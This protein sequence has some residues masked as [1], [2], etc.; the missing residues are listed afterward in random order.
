[1]KILITGATG[2]VGKH[3]VS[4]LAEQ[5]H[6]LLLATRRQTTSSLATVVIDNIDTFEHWDRHLQGIDVVIHLAAMV[7]QMNDKAEANSYYQQT[8]FS[9]TSRLAESAVACGVKRFIF[10]STI[11]VHGEA[12]AAGQT[13]TA[14]DIPSPTEGYAESKF[15]AEMSLKRLSAASGLELVIIRPPLVYGPGVKAN[16]LRLLDLGR[17][18]F[19]LPFAGLHNHRDMVSVDNLCDLIACCIEDHRAAG[20][21]FLV[22]DGIAYSTADI[23]ASTRSVL[24]LPRRLFY[25]PPW[26]LRWLLV[27][28]GK[29]SLADRLLGSLQVDI[30]ATEQTLNWSPKYTLEQTLRKM[31]H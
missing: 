31:L 8:N 4:L 23:I 10:L 1:M 28:V 14:A 30:S 6:Q 22:S 25:F 19:A 11:K 9:A 29:K 5:G 26:L 18:G 7:H 27:L 16:F 20:N 13:F 3:L 21:T 2:F 12:T 15:E 24:G 17:S